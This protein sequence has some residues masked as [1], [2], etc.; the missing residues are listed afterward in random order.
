MDE[1]EVAWFDREIT[2]CHFANER[3]KG[4]FR[5]LIVWMGGSGNIS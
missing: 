4:R 2:G 1:D 5:K 3:L